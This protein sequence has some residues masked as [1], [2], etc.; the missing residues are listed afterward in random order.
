MNC[1][2]CG[3]AIDSSGAFPGA[4]LT[5]PACGATAQLAGLP[6]APR[7]SEAAAV[8]LAPPSACP[9][10]RSELEIRHE[11][12]IIVSTC[13]GGHGVLVT[14]ATLRELHRMASPSPIAD[15]LDPETS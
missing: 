1:P 2:S 12:A 3:G 5:C 13:P 7:R 8:P 6:P 11:G 4:S 9:R 14:H 10:C 15:A